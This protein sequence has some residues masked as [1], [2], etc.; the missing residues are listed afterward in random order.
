MKRP[1]NAIIEKIKNDYSSERE[2]ILRALARD[3]NDMVLNQSYSLA[4]AKANSTRRHFAPKHSR[5]NAIMHQSPVKIAQTNPVTP[6]D[7]ATSFP[8]VGGRKCDA[9]YY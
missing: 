7:T 5:M 1:Y 8:P 9:S 2:V 6:C 4:L 3:D